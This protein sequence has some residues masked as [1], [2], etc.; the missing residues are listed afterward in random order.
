MGRRNIANELQ[1]AYAAVAATSINDKTEQQKATA[2][3]H[4]NDGQFSTSNNNNGTGKEEKPPYSYAQLIVQAIS[5]V[6]DRQLTLSGI[7]SY[8]TKNYPFYRTADRSWQVSL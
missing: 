2:I 5:S 6:S 3:N 4:N 8:I 1:M 7:Y